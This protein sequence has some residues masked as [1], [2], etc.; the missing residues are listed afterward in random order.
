MYIKVYTVF[1]SNNQCLSVCLLRLIPETAGPNLT[2]D[3]LAFTG[4]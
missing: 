3:C 2:G 4:K 1:T